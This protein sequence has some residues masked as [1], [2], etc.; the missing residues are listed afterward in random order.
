[1][2]TW[3]P[4]EPRQRCI[5]IDEALRGLQVKDKSWWPCE[6]THLTA[7]DVATGAC[8]GCEKGKSKRLPFPPFEGKMTTGSSSFQSG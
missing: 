1:M 8:E 7:V 5:Q 2:I 4:Q 3:W 6:N